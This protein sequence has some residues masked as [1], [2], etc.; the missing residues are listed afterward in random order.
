MCRTDLAAAK[1]PVFPGAEGAGVFT[2]GGRGGKVLKVTRLDDPDTINP[3]AGSLRWALTQPGPRIVVFAVGGTI[4]LRKSIK[5]REPFLTI[6]GQTAPGDGVTIRNEPVVIQTHDIVVRYVRFRLG[7]IGNTDADNGDALTIAG[8]T[9]QKMND[10]KRL[11]Y[12]IVIDHCS[13]SWGTDETVSFYNENSLIRDHRFRTQNITFSW[14][15]IAEPLACSPLRPH[16]ECEPGTNGHSTALYFGL[17]HDN[18]TIHHN[19]IAHSVRRNPLIGDGHFEVINNLIFNAKKILNITRTRSSVQAVSDPTILNYIGNMAMSA[20]QTR[21]VLIGPNKCEDEKCAGDTQNLDHKI[22]VRDNIGP[23]RTKSEM[24]E[25][26]CVTDDWGDRR[27]ADKKWQAPSPYS[28]PDSANHHPVRTQD[29][30]NAYHDVLNNAGASIKRDAVDKRIVSEVRDCYDNGNCIQ[31]VID[32]PSFESSRRHLFRSDYSKYLITATPQAIAED[33]YPVLKNGVERKDSDNDGM[34]DDWETQNG[35]NPSKN[36]SA[37]S[38]LH[39]IYTN[40]EVY[41]NSIVDEFNKTNKQSNKEQKSNLNP[42]QTLRVK[43]N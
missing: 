25:W 26:K 34:P 16:S 11:T 37:F 2:V 31:R 12:N 14:N 35:L 10:P 22:Y 41:I 40:I 33:G 19:L 30:K 32:S 39:S 15:I 43:T 4:G 13:F 23:V 28:W 21:M 5:I 38:N 29:H 3:P 27:D 6:A 7:E 9:S 42:P 17:N 8:P 1:I 24:D 20:S 36:D 18:I